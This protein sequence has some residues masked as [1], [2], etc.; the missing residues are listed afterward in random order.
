MGVVYTCKKLAELIQKDG[1]VFVRQDGS[2]RHYRHPEKR[3]IVTIPVHNKDL[4]KGTVN[5]ILKQA[6]LK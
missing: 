6:G 2:H 5:N 4:K 1:W 3:G